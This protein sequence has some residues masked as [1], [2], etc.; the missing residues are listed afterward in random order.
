M[1]ASN[2]W[3]WGNEA[4]RA[5]HRIR[6]KNALLAAVNNA[7]WANYLDRAGNKL[8][9]V[10]HK[11][12]REYGRFASAIPADGKLDID[13]CFRI[14]FL[15]G[16]TFAQADRNQ[17]GWIRFDELSWVKNRVV[18]KHVGYLFVGH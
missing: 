1:S 5:Q 9:D 16:V 8:F 2:T 15:A 4:Q 10:P 3:I 11:P 13:E 18:E 7:G 12:R 14:L 6:E 17:D